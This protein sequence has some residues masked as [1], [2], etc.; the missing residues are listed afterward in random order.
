M[1][2]VMKRS[3]KAILSLFFALL[4]HNATA[5]NN[6]ITIG[7]TLPLTGR[8]A[9]VGEDVRRGNPFMQNLKALTSRG[10]SESELKPATQMSDTCECF[11]PW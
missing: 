6:P 1:I 2:T 10:L 4:A 3:N 9:T 8:L 7:A 5:E 11:Y